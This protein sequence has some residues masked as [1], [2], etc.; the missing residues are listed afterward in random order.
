MSPDTL[1]KSG[2]AGTILAALCCFTPILVWIFGAIGLAAAV[3]WIDVIALP[4]LAMFTA[5]TVFALRK[6]WSR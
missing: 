3:G 5:V 2:I 6:R 4:A 1:L